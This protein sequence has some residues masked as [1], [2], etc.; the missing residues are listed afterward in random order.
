MSFEASLFDH[1]KDLPTEKNVIEAA[2][3]AKESVS[4]KSISI[5]SSTI[6]DKV[7]KS[8][9]AKWREANNAFKN[10]LLV[11]TNSV[12]MRVKR[13]LTNYAKN[14]RNKTTGTQ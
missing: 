10:P 5:Y 1:I 3:F 7:V 8:V 14:Q 13:I 11:E 12:F 4:D 9:E 2:L 6:V